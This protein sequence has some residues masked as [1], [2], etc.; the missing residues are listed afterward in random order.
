M[1]HFAKIAERCQ[2]VTAGSSVSSS[3]FNFGILSQIFYRI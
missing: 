2:P 1:Q 3:Q